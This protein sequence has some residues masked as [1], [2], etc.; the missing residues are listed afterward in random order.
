M[1]RDAAVEAAVARQMADLGAA[2]HAAH[3]E[4]SVVLLGSLGA[5]EAVV[6]RGAQGLRWLSD[7]EVA[8]VQPT[9][10]P[11]RALA[12]ARAAAREAVPGADV[13][14]WW[15]S[16]L[17]VRLGRATGLTRNLW[18]LRHAS[19]VLAG[20]DRVA[21]LPRWAPSELPA[22][23][24][25]RLLFN[26]MAE[27]LAAPPAPDALARAYRDAKLRTGAMDAVLL[28]KGRYE[29]GLGRRLASFEALG[30]PRELLPE[31]PGAFA[32]A[33]AFRADPR[34]A[35]RAGV[36]G[37]AAE[38][39]LCMLAGARAP[40]E[41]LERMARPAYWRGLWRPPLLGRAVA[42]AQHRQAE[43]TRRAL[44]TLV[45]GLPPEVAAY[46]LVAASFVARRGDG[47][48][49]AVLEQR[50]KLP[51]PRA[52]AVALDAWRRVCY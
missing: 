31:R 21:P 23:E 15:T 19:R 46:W 5:G 8:L 25:Y 29:L 32:E 11:P 41:A 9:P 37:R 3:P 26:R 6:A 20:P 40:A 22:W 36:G 1:S 44:R 17:R 16:P 2:L 39:A 13:G 33:I 14:V 7:V 30:G 42:R 18:D 43:G 48:A 52:R 50:A 45:R 35:S 38:G 49:E 24:G 51:A 27:H 47:D 12:R 28:A 34:P 10:I 4:A